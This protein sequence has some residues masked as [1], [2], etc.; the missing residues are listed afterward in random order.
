MDNKK[1]RTLNAQ[2]IFNSQTH[3]LWLLMARGF[4]RTKLR[5]GIHRNDRVQVTA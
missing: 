1:G 5:S 4:A 3:A 2:P